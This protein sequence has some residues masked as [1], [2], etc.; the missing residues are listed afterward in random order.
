MYGFYLGEIIEIIYGIE[1]KLEFI[2]VVVLFE[3]VFCI[4]KVIKDIDFS[5]M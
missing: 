3:Y 2:Y 1:D 5:R 4:G